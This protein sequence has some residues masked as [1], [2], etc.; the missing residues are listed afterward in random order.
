M[1]YAIFILRRARKELARLPAEAYEPTKAAI[2][3][4]SQEPRPRLFIKGIKR[5]EAPLTNSLPSPF[6]KGRGIKGEGLVNNLKTD[7][8]PEINRQGGLA[9]PGRRLS[10]NLRD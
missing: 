3:D 5:G 9:Y 1:N 7:W 2:W 8:M 4:L 6:M 10:G